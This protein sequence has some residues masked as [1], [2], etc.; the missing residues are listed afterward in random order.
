MI[1][2]YELANGTTASIDV[3]W[4]CNLISWVVDGNEL[5]YC[6]QELYSNITKITGAGSPL[7]FPA[8]GRTWDRSVTP[9]VKCNYRI[10]GSDKTY[11]MPTHGII[12]QS[13]FVKVEEK[14]CC[15]KASVLYK[16]EIPKEVIEENYPFDVS[17]SQ[18][19]TFTPNTIEL[20]TIMTN[21]GSKPAPAAFGHHPYFL[22]S[23]AN[24]EGVEVRLPVTTWLKTDLDLVLFTGESE[25]ADGVVKLQADVEYD[26]VYGGMTG[27]RM[28]LIDS[29]AGRKIWVDFDDN[30]ELMTIYSLAGTDFVCIEPW[31]R[32][33]G[34]FE[35][36]KNPGWESGEAIPVLAPGETKTLKAAYGVEY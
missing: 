15:D 27:N 31:T 36:L 21:N 29:K 30:F 10:Y 7:L 24:R 35:E 16:L 25:P 3:G 26:H 32:G 8:L 22:I 14:K 17:F 13:K 1:D 11:F 33:L 23:N 9:P 12:Y 6:P 2:R 28:E 5:M 20:A 19:F 18:R 34:A 4:G